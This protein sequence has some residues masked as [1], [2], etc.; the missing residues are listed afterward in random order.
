[1]YM[2]ILFILLNGT[3]SQSDR[4]TNKQTN[5]VRIYAVIALELHLIANSIVIEANTNEI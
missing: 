3:L 2:M 5:R 1:M 4:H